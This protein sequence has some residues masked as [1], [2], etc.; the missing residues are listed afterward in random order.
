MR[1]PKG[2]EHVFDSCNR[3]HKRGVAVTLSAVRSDLKRERGKSVSRHSLVIA[4]RAWK[5]QRLQIVSGRVSAAVAA[6]LALGDDLERDA[7]RR[8]VDQQSGGAGK[9]RFTVAS[10]NTGGGHPR[11]K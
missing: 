4:V 3:V 7:C 8:T 9:I 11:R 6:V 5:E 1:E 10:R 2:L